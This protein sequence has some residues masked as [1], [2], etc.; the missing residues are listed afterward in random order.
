MLYLE[1]TEQFLTLPYQ[2]EFL[3]GLYYI[4]HTVFFVFDSLFF[5]LALLAVISMKSWIWHASFII[6][7]AN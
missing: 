1:G 7:N 5:N 4:F 2:I 6:S 3:P